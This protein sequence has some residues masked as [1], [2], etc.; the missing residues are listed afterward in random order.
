MLIVPTL[1]KWW[2]AKQ[3]TNKN[4][5]KAEFHKRKDSK[6]NNENGGV[7]NLR[8]EQIPTI[9]VQ[10]VISESIAG[11]VNDILI[12]RTKTEAE[13]HKKKKDHSLFN[14]ER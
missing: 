9:R 5:N 13:H 7:N 11:K 3:G 8:A 2:R 12:K 4:E 1:E 6:R 10:Q 14:A